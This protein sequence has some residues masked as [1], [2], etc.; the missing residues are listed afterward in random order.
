MARTLKEIGLSYVGISLDGLEPV[1]DH[2]RGGER[3]LPQGH[4][5]HSQLPGAGIKVGLRFTINKQ[6]VK[7]IPA[8]S[9]CWNP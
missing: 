5:R 1:N 6:N 2:F 3:G 8:S 7:E 4:E 9:I